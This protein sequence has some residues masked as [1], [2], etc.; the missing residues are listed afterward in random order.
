[1]N[2]HSTPHHL[3][4]T[5]PFLAQ[6][7]I[8]IAL[9]TLAQHVHIHRYNYSEWIALTVM[10]VSVLASVTEFTQLRNQVVSC[11]L[12]LRDLEK[13][14]VWWDALSLVRRRTPAVKAQIVDVTEA[15]LLTVVDAHTTSASN[16]QLSVEK[17]LDGDENESRE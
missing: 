4:L 10:L 6:G 15:A 5:K 14:L 16:T 9:L 1:V 7:P 12:A 8:A 13:L 11:N 2:P 17:E 3:P